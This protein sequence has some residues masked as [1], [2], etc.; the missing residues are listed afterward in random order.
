MALA[1]GARRPPATPA[2]ATPL[3]WK[4]ESQPPTQVHLPC[5]R[6]RSAFPPPSRSP[7]PAARRQRERREK[8]LCC[9]PGQRTDD[10]PRSPIYAGR[11]SPPHQEERREKPRAA[12]AAVGTWCN[13]AYQCRGK[14]GNKNNAPLA[15]I[16]VFFQ[17][18]PGNEQAK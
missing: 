5:R 7:F 3:R 15:L 11:P 16:L 8:P 1:A 9:V 2:G 14:F 17:L 12:A 6:R 18:D 4:S 10:T 13:M